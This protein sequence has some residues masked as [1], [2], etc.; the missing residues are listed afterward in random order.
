MK[1]LVSSLCSL[2]SVFSFL[3]PVNA[4]FLGSDKFT[5]EEYEKAG[6]TAKH[7]TLFLDEYIFKKGVIY[8]SQTMAENLVSLY[9]I[10]FES[11]DDTENKKIDKIYMAVAQQFIK[12]FK[13]SYEEISR[14]SSKVNILVAENLNL[15]LKLKEYE[16]TVSES[17]KNKKV[18]T[19]KEII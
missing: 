5:D 16:R 4:F 10:A 14:L 3:S 17:G 11:D 7:H 12:F 18:D 9:Q 19:N 15:E 1:K 6:I 13:E 2:L 8:I